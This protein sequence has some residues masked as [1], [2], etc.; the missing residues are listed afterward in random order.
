MSPAFA[1]DRKI[2]LV[3]VSA[4][5]LTF[6]AFSAVAATDEAICRLAV[7][8]FDEDGLH[9]WTPDKNE[10]LVRIVRDLGASQLPADGILIC[11]GEGWY[12]RTLYLLRYF[13]A[14]TL[15]EERRGLA[16][17]LA[18]FREAPDDIVRLAVQHE[19][20]HLARQLDNQA[21]VDP[22]DDEIARRCEQEA[23][24]AAAVI[25]GPCAVARLLAWLVG[26][27]ERHN[28]SIY[29]GALT[30]RIARQMG[31]GNCLVS[32]ASNPIRQ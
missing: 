28:V 11:S 26:Y 32:G 3:M 8:W 17:H 30:P 15:R 20:G 2:A 21:C 12:G 24:D 19:L 18:F 5:L 9:Y 6:T 4:V 16:M 31:A 29:T 13:N 14:E 7:N 10:R 22:Y 23:D 25:V 27:F 1:R